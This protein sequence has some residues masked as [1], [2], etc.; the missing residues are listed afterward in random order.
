LGID[1]GKAQSAQIELIDKG[2]NNPHRVVF[3]DIVI[4]QRWQQCGL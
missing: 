1:P 2:I 4:Q 3:A